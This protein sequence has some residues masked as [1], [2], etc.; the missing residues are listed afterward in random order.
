MT[1][2]DLIAL[3]GISWAE[4]YDANHGVTPSPATPLGRAWMRAANNVVGHGPF[5][6]T[7]TAR[8]IYEKI[9]LGKPTIVFA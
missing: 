8:V 4:F 1:L 2:L 6:T 9:I 7:M 5:D 3:A